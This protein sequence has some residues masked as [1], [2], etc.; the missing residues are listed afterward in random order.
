MSAGIAI[1]VKTPGR[2]PL[3]TRLAAGVGTAFAETWH[4]QAAGTVAAVARETVR[5]A[6]ATAYWAVAEPEAFTD[7]R[8]AGLP[9]LGQGEGGLGTR[10]HHVH[11]SL[12]ERHRAGI[13]LGAD[14]PQIDPQNLLAALDWLRAPAARIVLGPAADGGFWLFGANR[15][16]PR[17]L[18]DAVPYSAP[19]TALRFR[20]A[21]DA[22]GEWLELPALDDVDTVAD[23]AACRAALGAL[24]APLPAQ[25]AL[26]AWLESHAPPGVFGA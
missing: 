2:S 24:P 3:K 12:V 6:G 16:L 14:T 25:A 23:L 13:L 8:W 26:K 17:A 20:A 7:P 1:F 5:R 4:T 22:W 19:D 9:I 21:F 10:M 18:W 15:S 11:V